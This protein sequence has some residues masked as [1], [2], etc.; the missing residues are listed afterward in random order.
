MSALLW[1]REAS[2]AQIGNLC[3]HL[4]RHILILH[5]NLHVAWCINSWHILT[6]PSQK[7]GLSSANNHQLW[8][9]DDSILT[10]WHILYPPACLLSQPGKP[11]LDSHSSTFCLA[12]EHLNQPT[13]PT[14][15]TQPTLT[16]TLKWL[17][18]V[19]LNTSYHARR[20]SSVCVRLFRPVTS[21]WDYSLHDNRGLLRGF[22]PTSGMFLT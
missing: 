12:L 15:P 11:T 22:N 5:V 20:K 14:G 8:L 18:A 1:F 13:K 7:H 10:L 16:S 21:S 9:N 6:S 4:S 17:G 19:T 3:W 2:M